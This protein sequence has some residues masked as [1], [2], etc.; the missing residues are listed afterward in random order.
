MGLI[1]I[2]I[3]GVNTGLAKLA[4]E[5]CEGFHA[6]PFNSPRYLH[7]VII[8][9]IAEGAEK[10]KRKEKSVVISVTAFTATTAEE[11]NFARTQISFYASTPS[12][13]SVMDF[14][15]W[16]GIAEKLSTQAAKGEWADMPKLITDEMLNEFCLVTSPEKSARELKARYQGI[17]DR[18]ALYTPFVPGE[19]D[20]FWKQIVSEINLE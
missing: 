18:L 5:L 16:G 2:Y 7:D 19:K 9:S 12:Y 6:H 15:G 3:G 4:G 11:E 13:R 17:A 14:Y 20:E 8:P 1:P 10:A